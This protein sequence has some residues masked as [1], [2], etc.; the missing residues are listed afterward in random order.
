MCQDL[1]FYNRIRNK[2][3]PIESVLITVY[4]TLMSLINK[5]D[6]TFE[7]Q[8]ST[9]LQ[10]ILILFYFTRVLHQGS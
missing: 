3:S 10:N 8:I 6:V 5:Q 7:N 1:L 4:Y 9:S 2:N